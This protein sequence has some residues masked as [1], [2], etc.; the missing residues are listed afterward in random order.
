MINIVVCCCCFRLSNA[1]ETWSSAMVVASGSCVCNKLKSRCSFGQPF[2]F[3]PI[4]L[5]LCSSQ[6]M[7]VY[8][9]P[10]QARRRQP[11][12]SH[13]CLPHEPEWLLPRHIH[14]QRSYRRQKWPGLNLNQTMH[15]TPFLSKSKQ[16]RFLTGDVYGFGTQTR[17]SA[18]TPHFYALRH[19]RPPA[20]E[21]VSRA[22]DGDDLCLRFPGNVQKRA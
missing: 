20:V 15:H 14:L 5:F 21:A 7:N 18:W 10:L 13:S 8:F 1:F 6:T 12:L 2:S 4:F 19:K 17:T 11:S 9:L 3:S 22:E 16:T